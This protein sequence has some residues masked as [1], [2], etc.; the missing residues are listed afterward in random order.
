MLKFF[1]QVPWQNCIRILELLES[2]QLSIK[3]GLAKVDYNEQKQVFEAKYENGTT[4]EFDSVINVT[5]EEKNLTKVNK[6]LY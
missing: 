2:K 3:G 1:T 4:E 5:G 6:P